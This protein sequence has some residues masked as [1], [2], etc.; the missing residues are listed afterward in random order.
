LLRR[1]H[2]LA[3]AADFARRAA[4]FAAQADAVDPKP[5]IEKECHK[6]CER[7]WAEYEKCKVRIAG[8]KDGLNCEPWTFD[9]W[10]C[11]D[12]CAAPK[13]FALLK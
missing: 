2:A 8:N 5:R 13:I 10:K 12:K 3:P 4:R 11:V 9:Y 1:A 6:P 7:Q